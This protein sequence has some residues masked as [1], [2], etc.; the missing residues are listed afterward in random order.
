M[1]QSGEMVFIHLMKGVKSL[2]EL[3]RSGQ[4]KIERDEMEGRNEERN[5]DLS[6]CGVLCSVGA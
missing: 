5:M 3:A 1:Q 4:N 2:D 6:F